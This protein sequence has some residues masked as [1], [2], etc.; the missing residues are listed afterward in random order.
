MYANDYINLLN[1]PSMV[2]KAFIDEEEL[3][4]VEKARQRGELNEREFKRLTGWEENESFQFRENPITRITLL[5]L[6]G[7]I[8]RSTSLDV[9]IQTDGQSEPYIVR[10]RTHPSF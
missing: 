7:E 4:L 3:E 2:L 9:Y 1:A 10:Q 8:S 6:K 5:T